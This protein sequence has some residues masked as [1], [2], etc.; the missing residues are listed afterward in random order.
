VCALSHLSEGISV[1]I[2]EPAEQ[3]SLE[4]KKVEKNFFFSLYVLS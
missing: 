4:E 1:G 2:C 3:G